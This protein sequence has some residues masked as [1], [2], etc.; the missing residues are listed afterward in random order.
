MRIRRY[1]IFA[2]LPVCVMLMA[3]SCE[4][5]PSV[6]HLKGLVINE[7]SAHDEKSDA[8]SW[9]EIT[10]TSG[11]EISLDGIGLYLTDQYFADKCIWSATQ[12]T[13]APDEK[14]VISTENESLTTGIAS[15]SQFVLR[16]GVGSATVDSFDR[17]KDLPDTLTRR[18]SYQRIPDGTGAWRKLTYP[19]KGRVNEV[20]D[21]D[22]VPHTAIWTWS[23]HVAGLMENDAANLKE[24][25]R[26]GYQHILLNYAAF[27][28]YNI[29]NTL[30]FIEKCE[31]LGLTVHCWMQCF[32][33]GGW[34]NPV[35]DENVCYKEEIFAD[36]REHAKTYLE[37][38]GVK[39]LH[40]DYIRFGGTAYKH[41]PSATVNAIGAVNRCCQEI[42]EIAD[43]FDAGLVTSAALM[44]ERNSTEY[45]GQ[46]PSL[47]GKYIHVLMP[48]CYRYSYNWSDS[49]CKSIVNWFCDNSGGSQV[50]AGITTYTGNDSG[51]V[52]GMTA[53][54]LRKD[55]D[56]FMDSKADG[57]VLFRCGLGTFPD[58]NDL[59]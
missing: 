43:S 32:Y 6:D 58:V 16:L 38:F 55:I 30:P 40:L 20:F 57:L 4:K 26:L 2:L 19:S 49:G 52:K 31:E 25:K 42:R 22:A 47:M 53:E 18:G 51:G 1:I 12:A 21:I 48:M 37:E 8:Y 14:I 46:S 35:D 29:K 13:I 36:I 15:D 39:G 24:F 56:V 34:I 59:K 7:I 27:E 44:P 28:T 41:N 5:E 10:N 45:Y 9:V 54:A 23:S 33:K 50:W 11:S 3:A 17:S